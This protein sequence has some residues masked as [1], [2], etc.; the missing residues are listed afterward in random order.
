MPTARISILGLLTILSLAAFETAIAE[1]PGNSIRPLG[2]AYDLLR[3]CPDDYCPKPLPCAPCFRA[4]CCG[5]Y[6]PKPCPCVRCFQD[7]CVPNCYLCKPSPDLYRPL[8]ANHFRCVVPCNRRVN[9]GSSEASTEFSSSSS[10]P[11][12]GPLAET[13]ASDDSPVPMPAHLP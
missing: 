8:A 13:E 7:D 3:C 5:G 4:C 2:C 1:R 11:P 6:C 10:I 12:T 9:P